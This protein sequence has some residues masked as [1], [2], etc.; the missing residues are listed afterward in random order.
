MANV[1]VI[2]SV[3]EI[4]RIITRKQEPFGGIPFIGLGDF[5]QVA[6]VVKGSGVTPALLASIKSSSLWSDFHIRSLHSPIRGA[7]D[8]EYTT[9][10]DCI[11][12]DHTHSHISLNILSRIYTLDEAISFLFPHRV[13]ADPPACLQRALLSPKNSYVDEF[14]TKI[15]DILPGEEGQFLLLCLKI[16]FVLMMFHTVVYYSADIVKEDNQL[17]EDHPEVTPDFLAILSQN[18]IPKHELHLKQGCI[19][20]LMRN[21]SVQKGLVKN[22]HLIIQELHHRYVEV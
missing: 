7:R 21:M 1:A 13:L 15:L 10:V 18:G 20:S 9:F 11:G 2:E 22:A 4:C 19:C 8:I 5:R 12:E 3:D 17:I 16:E 6:P 14:N